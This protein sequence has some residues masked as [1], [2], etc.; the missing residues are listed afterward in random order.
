MDDLDKPIIVTL[1]ENPV[2][3]PLHDIL[4]IPCSAKFITVGEANPGEASHPTGAI[5]IYEVE[6]G[7]ITMK[8]QVS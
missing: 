1:S 6:E 2:S 4:W 7:K 8:K 3:Y 5:Q